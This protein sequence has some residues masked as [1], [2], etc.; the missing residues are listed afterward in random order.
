MAQINHVALIA[1][2]GRRWA[3]RENVTLR[4]S[5]RKMMDLL[6]L[7]TQALFE[8]GIN[9][10]SLYLLSKE[11]L[12]R[13][14]QEL[15]AALTEE[16][17]FVEEVVPDLCI[18]FNANAKIAGAVELLPESWQYI[19]LPSHQPKMDSQ[20][21][22]NLCIAYSPELELAAAIKEISQSSDMKA[23]IR[24]LWV[25]EPVDLLIRTGGARTLSNFIPLQCGY[26]Q[27]VFL[28]ELFNDTSVE[29][30]LSIVRRQMI[31]DF[32]FGW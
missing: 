23:I 30:I 19:K 28:D 18:K 15:E 3:A 5:Y 27:L 17:R 8:A 11:N 21:T 13:T 25:S 16:K 12:R 22:L 2:G 14:Q 4:V 24:H 26:A 1:D 6:A 32:K 20:K 10:V 29:T 7:D 9:I 31:Q